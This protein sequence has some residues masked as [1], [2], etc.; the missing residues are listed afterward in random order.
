MNKQHVLLHALCPNHFNAPGF[1]RLLV[2]AA[3]LAVGIVL[4][5]LTK[6]KTSAA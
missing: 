6:K 1:G 5:L 3:M 2:A 4:D